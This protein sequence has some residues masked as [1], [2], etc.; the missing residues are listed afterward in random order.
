MR[1]P[2]DPALLVCPKC[3]GELDR[4]GADLSCGP[5][6]ITFPVVDGIPRMVPEEWLRRRR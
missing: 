2:V 1:P 4:S 3:R 5:C 6:R